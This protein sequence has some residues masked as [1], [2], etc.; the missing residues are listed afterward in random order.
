MHST[1]KVSDFII[2]QKV[3]R[4]LE[5]APKAVPPSWRDQLL[6]NF[7]TKSADSVP[8]YRTSTGNCS[9]DRLSKKQ[10]LAARNFR[11]MI[12]S[13]FFSFLNRRCMRKST[14]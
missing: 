12:F 7:E 1:H 4:G 6:S 2:N 9:L 11:G 10:K 14:A 5:S 8:R 13:R 3:A